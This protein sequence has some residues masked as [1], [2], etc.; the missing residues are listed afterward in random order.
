M[1]K[2]TTELRSICE[3]FAELTESV[4]YKK[5]DEVIRL[6]LPKI[7]YFDFPIFDENHRTELE[8]KIIKHYYTREI[9]VETVG[10]W[11]LKLEMTMN[12]IMP[13][14][15]QLYESVSLKYNP[16]HDVDI[17]RTVNTSLKNN[18]DK[19]GNSNSNSNSS[20]SS[21]LNGTNLNLLSDT[22][23]GGLQN[24]E[25]QDYLTSVTKAVNNQNDTTTAN[26]M[27]TS[28]DNVK[29]VSTENENRNETISGKQGSG[30]YAKMIAEY[31]ENILNVDMMIIEELNDLFMLLW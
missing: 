25:N 22:P 11:L 4:G 14:Y 15:N 5:V 19:T 20:G 27:N 31:R 12:E 8:T 16:L 6:A 3:Q 28:S 24:I 1:S 10:L 18:S 26:M 9:G 29:E 30:S 13:Y 7:F 21:T 23:Q 2:Y 17:T